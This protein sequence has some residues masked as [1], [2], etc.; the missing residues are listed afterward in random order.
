MSGLLPPGMA[1]DVCGAL[2][3][4]LLVSLGLLGLNL[5]FAH[6]TPV[7]G[8][9]PA[10]AQGPAVVSSPGSPGS[11]GPAGSAPAASAGSTPPVSSAGTTPVP[12]VEESTTPARPPLTVLNHSRIT[13]LAAR[14][15]ED[16]RTGGWQVVEVG[17][18]RREVLVTTVFFAAGQE[19]AAA[20][21]RQ[22]FP[23]IREMAPRPA[24][25]PGS[26]LTVVVTREYRR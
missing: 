17:N 7:A 16:F 19:A 3:A 5:G 18:T 15:A 8:P 24:D 22:A 9:G 14:A 26:G 23:A 6:K 21:L 11:P 25:L 1:R 10:V 13:G 12:A 2:L 4:V 20:E